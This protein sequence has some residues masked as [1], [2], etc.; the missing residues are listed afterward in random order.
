[1]SLD[2]QHLIEHLAATHGFAG[3]YV[4]P[5]GPTPSFW[6]FQA[7]L[8]GGLA[9]DMGYLG[10]ALETRA[11]PR[12]R[13][14]T[15]RSAVVLT[16]HHAHEVPEDPGGAT[17]LVARYAWGRDYHNLIGKRVRRLRSALR[18]AG[19]SS[20]GGVD[21]APIVERA[22]AAAAG[23]GFSGKNA[24]QI[25][26][27]AGSWTLLAVIFVDVELPATPPAP[28]RCG[29]C[30]RCLDTCPTGALIGPGQV[31]AGRCL[32]Y[33]SIESRELAPPEITARW[34]RHL[35]GC[36]DC[37]AVCPHNRKPAPPSS[38]DLLPRHA[39]VDLTELLD[40]PD[41][42]LRT[43]YLGTPLL[44]PGPAGLKRNALHALPFT[45]APHAG[46]P[47]AMRALSH[48]SEVVRAAGI[49]TLHHLA[50]PIPQQ[51]ERDPSPL[52][53]AERSRP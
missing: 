47:A 26:P 9:A 18:E 22:W 16:T 53:Q 48:P 38:P 35:L 23:A 20:W 52:V 15:A 4:A 46:I 31:D 11:D 30:T 33:W 45:P 29:T 10:R 41:E 50:V 27:G 21:T 14:P 49:R 1:M 7:W 36:D 13:L 37:Q 43:R 19:I 3:V 44:R 28:A 32:S 24:C 25:L 5:V 17:A 34:G 6:R 51:T 8:D 12:V 2:P 39:W 42:A 40:T